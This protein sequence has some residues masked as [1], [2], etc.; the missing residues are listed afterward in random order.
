MAASSS[1]TA[2]G[3]ASSVG[4][5]SATAAGAV[6]ANGAGAAIAGAAAPAAPPDNSASCCAISCICR[7]EEHTSELQSHMRI[8][9][10]VLCMKKKKICMNK[11]TDTDDTH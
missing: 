6:A 9:Y 5:G 10:A 8:S 3:A 1:S 7:S 2:F 4:C 11:Q